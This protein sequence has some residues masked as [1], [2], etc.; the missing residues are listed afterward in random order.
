MAE[1]RSMIELGAHE[2][3]AMAEAEPG[4]LLCA[5]AGLTRTRRGWPHTQAPCSQLSAE[6]QRV[7]QLPQA[8]GSLDRSRHSRPH[9]ESGSGHAVLAPPLAVLA[10]EPPCPL[11]PV[12][13][14]APPVASAIPA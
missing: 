4:A 9:A 1:A 10:P 3:V 6:P 5:L 11:P 14:V 8:W 13:A 7:L 12:P 2:N